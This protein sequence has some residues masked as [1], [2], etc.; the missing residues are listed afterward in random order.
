MR[1]SRSWQASLPRQ[2]P[3]ARSPFTRTCDCLDCA[4]TLRKRRR[5]A[6]VS[7]RREAT[8]ENAARNFN[9]LGI[10]YESIGSYDGAR[11][12]FEASLKIA[13]RAAATMLNLAYTELRAG[14][15]DAAEKR[16]SEALF[17]YP[18]LAPALNG[19][20]EA[21]DGQG[22]TRRAAAIRARS[23]PANH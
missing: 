23:T 6:N 16:F 5:S 7:R 8:P 14:R 2:S 15:P 18:T 12:A 11:R 17:V 3:I 22:D 1:G 9:L 20:A 4:A 13:P 10:A 19:L 21:L